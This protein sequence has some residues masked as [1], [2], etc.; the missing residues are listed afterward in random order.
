MAALKN[1]FLAGV[2]TIFNVF[3]EAVI[4]GTYNIVDDNG[5]DTPFTISDT[6]RCIFEKSFEKDVELL[7]F[8][9]LIQPKDVIGLIPAVDFV[10][11]AEPITQGNCI[12][13][14]D[15]YEV[16]GH[17]VDPM[18]VIYTVLLRRN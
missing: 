6:I 9:K 14:A 10:N 4:S 13:G 11:N 17:D 12:F 5:F 7:T 8:Y 3:N 1:I 2:E 15:K 18:T 16:V